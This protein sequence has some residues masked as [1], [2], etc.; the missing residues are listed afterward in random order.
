MG[1]DERAVPTP[2]GLAARAEERALE[3]VGAQQAEP[4]ANAAVEEAL[5]VLDGLAERPLAEHVAAFDA[6]HNALQD[7]LAEAQ[8]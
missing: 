4:G 1:D 8:G 3:R 5:R 7:R 2:A 6:V